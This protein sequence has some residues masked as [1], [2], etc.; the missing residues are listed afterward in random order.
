MQAT[1][2]VCKADIEFRFYGNPWK[3]ADNLRHRHLPSAKIFFCSAKK[4]TEVS[5]MISWI[6]N[7]SGSKMFWI[8]DIF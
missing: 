1:N 6:S 4:A 5:L 2:D 8:L 3:L 7:F